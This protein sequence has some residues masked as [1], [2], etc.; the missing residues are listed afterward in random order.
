MPKVVYGWWYMVGGV[1][2]WWVKNV[3]NLRTRAGK[4]SVQ[5]SPVFVN[6]YVTTKNKLGKV[7][8]L[9]LFILIFTQCLSTCKL[10]ISYLLNKRYT[11]NPQHLL[12]EPL[13]KI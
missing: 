13:K 7:R 6:T 5:L 12:I 2:S 4:T 11:H 10:A 1:I 3:H 8:Q 9:P